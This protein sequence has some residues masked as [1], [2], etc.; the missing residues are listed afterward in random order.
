MVQYII[1]SSGFS[2]FIISKHF[3]LWFNN[4]KNIRDRRT[5]NFKTFY[6]MV[7]FHCQPIH[8]STLHHFKTFY[9]MVQFLPLRFPV[10]CQHISKHFMLWFN[11]CYRLTRIG[12]IKFQNIL[13]YGSIEIRS[14]FVLT[15]DRFQNIL[16]Y[17]SIKFLTFRKKS[18][19]ISKH[20]MLW[21]NW[22][23][24]TTILCQQDFKTFY[25]MVQFHPL[26]FLSF[27]VY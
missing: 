7:Q 26:P 6:V 21:F 17:G 27:I 13:C 9:V 19:Y 20:F 23:I 4:L 15:L 25:V 2:K 10:L 24:T 8:C 11:V 12:G 5:S 18:I 1:S 3:M 16:C 22:K 14:E